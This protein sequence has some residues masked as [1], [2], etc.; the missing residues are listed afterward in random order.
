MLIH[1]TL[2]TF[3]SVALELIRRPSSQDLPC[4]YASELAYGQSPSDCLSSTTK[5]HNVMR[6]AQ[7]FTLKAP[8]AK[9]FVTG[10][11]CRMAL[12]LSLPWL[13]IEPD[14]L[15]KYLNQRC[16]RTHWIKMC[17]GMVSG[18]HCHPRPH[19]GCWEAEE[20]STRRL[21]AQRDRWVAR[22]GVVLLTDFT[23]QPNTFAFH[24]HERPGIVLLSNSL[25]H[26]SIWRLVRKRYLWRRSNRIRRLRRKQKLPQTMLSK[27]NN[28]CKSFSLLI[29]SK[30]CQSSWNEAPVWN[31]CRF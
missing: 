11:L 2:H 25:Q 8:Q 10:T 1:T 22:R 5:H 3:P 21:E 31:D 20:S 19:H 4:P 6:K 17:W 24:A 18:G 28:L 14:S 30:M 29:M 27:V 7:H 26:P 15:S 16:I 9:I 12:D 13:W 23:G